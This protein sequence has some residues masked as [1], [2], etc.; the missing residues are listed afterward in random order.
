MKPMIV[1]LIGGPVVIDTPE[2]RELAIDCVACEMLGSFFMK[3]FS[4]EDCPRL[5]DAIIKKI[6]EAGYMSAD[7]VRAAIKGGGE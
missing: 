4:K 1:N 5:A 7:D 3:G 6:V 2:R